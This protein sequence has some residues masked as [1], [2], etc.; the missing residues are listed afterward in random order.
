MTRPA[1][2]QT[3]SVRGYLRRQG[4]LIT[5]TQ[6]LAAGMTDAA[7]KNKIRPNG[8][9][10]VVLPGIYLAASGPLGI[11]QREMAAV[12]YAGPD[13]VITG[14]AA[15]QRQGLAQASDNLIV[16]VLVPA[17]TQR[18]S[19]GFVRVHRTR[20]LPAK[21]LHLSDLRYAEAARAVA[22]AIWGEPDRNQ[23]R[24]LIA[25]AVQREICTVEQ[26]VVELK[27]GP[28]Q[29]RTLF[30]SALSEVAAG[31]LS[32]AEADFAGLIRR[33]G[34]PEPM[35]NPRLFAGPVFLAR[36]DAWWPDAGVA[37]EV[38]SREWHLSPAAWEQTMARHAR[39]SAHGIIVLHFSP[40]QIARE[41]QRVL[42]ELRSAIEAGRRRPPLQVRAVAFSQRG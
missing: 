8:P 13:C 6:A 26:L 15:L 12:L 22:D 1:S 32:V 18:Q 14:R 38:D 35:F 30:R 23:V 31:T 21:P 33:S 9:W 3:G 36:P 7:L 40:R 19:M 39:M 16:D 10:Q 24:Q 29:G 27:A 5:R 11:G 28:N 42:T 41:Q 25:A 17:P 34:L 37:A 20:R 2:G 4:N